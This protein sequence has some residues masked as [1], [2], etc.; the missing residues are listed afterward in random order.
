MFFFC[1]ETKWSNFMMIDHFDSD[2]S[3]SIDLIDDQS[4]NRLWSIKIFVLIDITTIEI[5]EIDILEIEY[6]GNWIFRK[7]IIREIKFSGNWIF[8][9]LNSLE[10][11][12]SG[13]WNSGNW[14]LG[15]G[16]LKFGKL[17]FGK[18]NSGFWSYTVWGSKHQKRS[19][20]LLISVYSCSYI[21]LLFVKPIGSGRYG[22]ERA[23][24]RWEI[25]IYPRIL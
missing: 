23:C 24:L 11:E 13:N 2:R 4:I 14:S 20:I 3:W 7:L 16:K 15:F 12:Y 6:S 19:K 1:F 10:I 9:K 18:S 5:R 17:K 21:S 8:R 25:I 22:K